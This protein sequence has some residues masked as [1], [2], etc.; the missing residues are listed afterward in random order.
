MTRFH[1]IRGLDGEFTYKM[2]TQRSRDGERVVT[3]VSADWNNDRYV[4][5]VEVG[6]VVISCRGGN[7]D[8]HSSARG[9]RAQDYIPVHQLSEEGVENR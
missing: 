1:R 5:G 8:G 6:R 9:R 4:G 7:V 3:R 2:R